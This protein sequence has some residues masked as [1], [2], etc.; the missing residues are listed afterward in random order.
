MMPD[1]LLITERCVMIT[2][3]GKRVLP[4]VYCRYETSSG[5]MAGNASGLS[6]RASN[7]AGSPIMRSSRPSVASTTKGMKAS[8]AIVTAAPLFSIRPRSC[9]TKL[10]C[11][12]RLMVAGRATGISP[13]YWQAKNTRRKSGCVSATIATRSPFTRPS[14]VNLRASTRH[15]A[16][17]S[18]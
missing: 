1:R 13:A 14:P 17:R 6:G 9:E 11:P 4:E 7:S 15:C 3:R 18:V 10:W 12:P 16:R 8:E 5:P 2:P